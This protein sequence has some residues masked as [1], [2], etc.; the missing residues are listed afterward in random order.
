MSADIAI[1]YGST[2]CYTQMA[3]ERMQQILGDD[4]CD[5]FNIADTP[6]NK[7]LN[8]SKL[9][10]G[11][12]T[13]DYGELQE[14]WDRVWDSIAELDLKDRT[15]AVFGLGDQIGYPD[16]FQDALGY[17]YQNLANRGATMRGHWPIDGYRFEASKALTSDNRHFVGL[18]LDDENQAELS[19]ERI[20]AWLES[21]NY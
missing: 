14:D 5:L 15:A 4:H 13:W 6:L 18:A 19:E 12:P 20:T 7:C 11:I 2:T 3:A 21:L 1:F 16:W 17:L 8:Y 9:I 10:F